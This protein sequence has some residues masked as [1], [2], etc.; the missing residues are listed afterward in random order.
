MSQG[1]FRGG[2]SHLADLFPLLF[3]RHILRED[4][5][6]KGLA[7]EQE[8]TNT[9]MIRKMRETVNHIFWGGDLNY[10]VDMT[11]EEA[12]QCLEAQG[13]Q[14]RIF[15]CLTPPR[16]HLTVLLWTRH[17]LPRTS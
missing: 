11:R 14:V 5:E 6:A 15:P 10:R 12:D 13:Y 8:G 7:E 9:D 2:T 1:P 3:I 4:G 17:F 16:Q